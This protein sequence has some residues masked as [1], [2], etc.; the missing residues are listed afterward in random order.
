MEE[1]LRQEVQSKVETKEEE[2]EEEEEEKALVVMVVLVEEEINE[3]I[4]GYPTCRRCQ[5][6]EYR[7]ALLLLLFLPGATP[8]TAACGPG[9]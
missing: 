8:C 6:R 1:R 9:R 2:E 4:G 5:I 3:G 7:F